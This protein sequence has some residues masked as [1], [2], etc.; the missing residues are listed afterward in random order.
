MNSITRY[1]KFLADGAKFLGSF[2]CNIIYLPNYPEGSRQEVS[3]P[4]DYGIPHYEDITLTTKDNVK[5]RIYVLQL[6][7]NITART[8]PT[9]LLFHGNAG[10]MGHCLPI[11]K[12]FYKNFKCNVVMLSYRGYGL[13]EGTPSEKG[14]RIDAQTVLDYIDK[15]DIFRHTKVIVYGQSLGGAVAIDLVSKNEDKVAGLIVENTFLSIPKL[16]PHVIPQLR[17]FSFC[18]TQ[19]WDSEKSIQLIKRI[20]V[21]FLSGDADKLIPQEHVKQLH[22]LVKTEGGK[23]L[24]Q[25]PFGSHQDTVSQEGYF[26]EIA[27]FLLTKVVD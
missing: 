3:E 7:D 10:N 23:K 9:I 8:R 1:C 13:S 12:Q 16:L 2:Q 18:C 27:E 22:D 15:H 5:I 14:L 24:K 25:F 17:H 19:K 20:P 6:G 21:L 11:A 4:L 26:E